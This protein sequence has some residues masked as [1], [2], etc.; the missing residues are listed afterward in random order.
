MANRSIRASWP[1]FAVVLLMALLAVLPGPPTNHRCVFDVLCC[2]FSLFPFGLYLVC[3]IRS[4]CLFI[5][6]VCVILFVLT[7]VLLIVSLSVSLQQFRF[8][9]HRFMHFAFSV[10]VCVLF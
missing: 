5:V 8:V 7:G 10:C 9:F 6:F 2:L 4:L 1:V 3:F